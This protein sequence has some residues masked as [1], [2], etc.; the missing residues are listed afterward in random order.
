M[1]NNVTQMHWREFVLVRL[2]LLILQWT[3]CNQP[4]K[5]GG[6]Q[7]I[8]LVLKKWPVLVWSL[9]LRSIGRVSMSRTGVQG[10]DPLWEGFS[11]TVRLVWLA[12]LLMGIWM[13][14]GRRQSLQSGSD[15]LSMLKE[16]ARLRAFYSNPAKKRWVG[17]WEARKSLLHPVEKLNPNV[18]LFARYAI[19][20]ILRIMPL[21]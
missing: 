14:H 4:R 12:E 1:L 6:E 8:S 2:Q 18:S 20:T 21:L 5:P 19:F 3:W 16:C 7:D 11:G 17:R 13:A 9:S 15:S 10:Q